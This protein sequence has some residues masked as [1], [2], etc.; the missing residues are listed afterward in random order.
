MSMSK[1][2]LFFVYVRVLLVSAKRE[3][4]SSDTHVSP[5]TSSIVMCHPLLH[6]SHLN[7]VKNLGRRCRLRTS[8]LENRK[9]V[10]PP[11]TPN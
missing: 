1:T 11:P 4:N 6:W 10:P 9:H 5:G 3:R 7:K 2:F 8:A